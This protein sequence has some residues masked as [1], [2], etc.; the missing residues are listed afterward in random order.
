[1]DVADRIGALALAQER[2]PGEQQGGAPSLPNG[3]G[4]LLSKSRES[5]QWIRGH[6]SSVGVNARYRR[7]FARGLPVIDHD[8]FA[9]ETF[10]I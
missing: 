8:E 4:L 2:I 6:S 10:V 1:V 7:P 3:R 5:R 9:T